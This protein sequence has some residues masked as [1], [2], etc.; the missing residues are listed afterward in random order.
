MTQ[1][2][3]LKA[4]KCQKFLPPH[5]PLPVWH[6][7]QRLGLATEKQYGSGKDTV[8]INNWAEGIS[9]F[10]TVIYQ[11]WNSTCNTHSDQNLCNKNDSGNSVKHWLLY[12]CINTGGPHL[13]IT[14]GSIAVLSLPALCLNLNKWVSRCYMF[15][16]WISY[17]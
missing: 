7:G 9:R 17:I 6:R 11:T 16:H 5:F 10:T 13:W 2:I 4:K 3:T 1:F 8:P 12:N 15:P 14:V